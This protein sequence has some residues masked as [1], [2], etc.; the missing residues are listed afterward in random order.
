MN[1][2]KGHK[3][4]NGDKVQ[5][6]QGIGQPLIV[7]GQTPETRRPSEGALNDPTFGQEDE[8]SLGI[9]QFDH[10]QVNALFGGGLGWFISS[11]ALVDES[12]LC[13]CHLGA[14]VTC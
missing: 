8:A 6:R 14:P 11:I 2:T 3:H 4:S 7:A 5:A 13:R 12:N 9:R 10:D 1:E